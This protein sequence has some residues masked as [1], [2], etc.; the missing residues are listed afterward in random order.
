M[1]DAEAR[2]VASHV[3]LVRGLVV[4]ALGIVAMVWPDVTVKVVAVLIGILVVIFGIGT[5]GHALDRRRSHLSWIGTLLGGLVATAGGFAAIFWPGPTVL[6]IARLFGALLLVSGFLG[7]LDVFV[8]GGNDP[9]RMPMA[10]VSAMAVLAGGL[11][12]V[13][14]DITIGVVVIIQ[15]IF[16]VVSGVVTVWASRQV[17]KA[18]LV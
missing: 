5:I 8:A 15:G 7:V 10:G 11:L 18:E 13:W 4:I 12:L 9:A 2:S 6:V 16:W 3:L 1:A 17:G 14:P